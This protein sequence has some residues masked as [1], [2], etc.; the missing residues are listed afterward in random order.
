MEAVVNGARSCVHV[1]E[2]LYDGYNQYWTMKA[3]LCGEAV[4]GEIE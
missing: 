2:W 3:V 1:E 4:S